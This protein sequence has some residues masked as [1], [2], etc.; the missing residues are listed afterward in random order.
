MK[1]KSENKLVNLGFFIALI[2]LIL[3][4]L[5]SYQSFQKTNEN[6]KW[7]R[8]TY[9]VLQNSTE[10]FSVIKDAEAS[11]RG[12][13]ITGNLKFLEP[14]ANSTSK[15][16]SLFNQIRLLIPDN[17]KQLQR[18]EQ[19]IQ[20]T[21]EKYSFIYNNISLRQKKGM[22][23]AM[24][25]INNGEGKRIMDEIRVVFH[26]FD[27][28][29][30]YLLEERG[31]KTE[32]TTNTSKIILLIGTLTSLCIFLIIFNILKKQIK[33]RR[34]NE[35]QL[36]IQNEWYT[37][38]LVSI[39]DGV[40]TTD[41]NGIISMINKTACQVIG[42]KNEEVI[43]KN[44][45]FVFNILNERTDQKVTN[46]ISIALQ[47]DKTVLLDE[48][49]ILIKKD[50]TKIYIDD[51]GSPI[52]NKEGEI[53]GAVLIFRDIT[54]KKKVELERDMFYNISIDM[55]GVAGND[56]YFK[57]INP[58]FQKTLG[59][60][61]EEFLSRGFLDF[62]HSDDIKKTLAEMEKLATGEPTLSFVN[63]YKCKDETYKWLEWNVIPVDEN[64][65]AMARDTTERHK[66]EQEIDA[67]RKKFFQI[68][69]S[70]P[71]A[72]VITEI[73]NRQIKYV[74]DA[75]CQ[76]SGF[77]REMMLG[78][79]ASDLKT[80]SAKEGEKITQK[81]LKAGGREK[82]MESKFRRMDGEEIDVL[83][84]VESLEIDGSMCFIGSFIDIS[85]RKKVEKEIK[86]LNQSLEKKV[87]K[88][89]EELQK[90]KE[91][92]DE[93][94]NK[95]PTEI[96]VYDHNKNYLYVN[97]KGIESE[98]IRD[99]IIGKSDFD[100]CKLKGI[101]D[102]IA[103]KRKESFEKVKENESV[104]WIDELITEDGDLKYMLRILHPL[105]SSDKYIL[106]GYDI[107]DLKK[108][109]QEKQQYINDLEQM[110]FMTSHKVRHPI[111]QLI[112][113]SNLL[114]EELSKEEVT[115]IISYIKNSILSLE[116]FTR[117]L[118][119]FIHESKNKNEKRNQ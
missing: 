28:E 94:L 39:G 93:I 61:D 4:S 20:L 40:I 38:T 41:T 15:K 85:Q 100:Y 99:W 60:T 75:F 116:T 34:E 12:Y 71:V 107:T 30:Q 54:E 5:F 117:E 52:H 36:F 76:M 23:E 48:N 92:T 27:K 51:S 110:M 91:F 46:P 55:I 43:G 68:L 105:E 89:T 82:N 21:K 106:T 78:K 80:I 42:C 109:E 25:E 81:I 6:E 22:N 64:L 73:K 88:R 103:N 29:E 114:E 17:K 16:D 26:Q 8:H 2:I 77:Q 112:G 90:Q 63:R 98:E 70:N 49:T 102:T 97:P 33:Q 3:L 13:I 69:E 108:A 32:N 67:A 10:L 62:V 87:E 50:G 57:R 18:I 35:E 83:F 58:A 45:D 1:W 115:G 7:V 66:A 47:E 74:N 19:L 96:A 111:S 37:Q 44:I 14:L 84:S 11:H 53:I 24:K 79:N 59:Y 113:I 101:D 119:M 104:E 86:R 31:I 95:I 65:Y 9:I 118:T 72:I 56:G